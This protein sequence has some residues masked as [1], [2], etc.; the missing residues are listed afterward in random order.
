MVG[1]VTSKG[2]KVGLVQAHTRHGQGDAKLGH[3]HHT[4]TKLVKIA[5]KLL[6]SHAIAIHLRFDV[7]QYVLHPLW[8]ARTTAVRRSGGGERLV[9]PAP[10]DGL[11]DVEGATEGGHVGGVCSWIGVDISREGHVVDVI[12]R[13]R[14]LLF[15]N[16]V[17]GVLQLHIWEEHGQPLSK[18]GLCHVSNSVARYDLVV[19]LKVRLDKHAAGHHLLSEGSED[20][21]ELLLFCIRQDGEGP[22]PA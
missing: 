20:G 15:E 17:V 14:V 9:C 1:I 12:A 22:L 3:A 2:S 5:E 18:L 13:I 21:G 10:S 4:G 16:L 8:D 11:G 19:V 6:A 7:I